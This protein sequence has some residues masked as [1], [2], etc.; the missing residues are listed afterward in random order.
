M[1]EREC[2]ACG[3][4][5]V[6]RNEHWKHCSKECSH[7]QY[8]VIQKEKN[9]NW[10]GGRCNHSG[11]V[12]VRIYPDHPFFDALAGKKEYVLEHRLIMSEMLGRPVTAGETVHHKNGVRDDNRPENLE[13]RTGQHG[14]GASIH[15]LTCKCDEKK[16]Q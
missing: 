7:N 11:Y 10:K 8:P 4:T 6:P 2:L 1:A 15:C 3:K 5:F 9:G 13:L 12:R 14:P 16:E